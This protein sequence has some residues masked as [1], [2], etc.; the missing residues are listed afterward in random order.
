[1][2]NDVHF[3]IGN[4]DSTG[5]GWV[6]KELDAA[7][8]TVVMTPDFEEGLLWTAEDIV[9]RLMSLTDE[10]GDDLLIVKYSEED[11]FEEVDFLHM[12][13]YVDSENLELTVQSKAR[14]ESDEELPTAGDEEIPRMEDVWR[15]I[16]RRLEGNFHLGEV[17]EYLIALP[18]VSDKEDRRYLASL[19][20][21]HLERY[22]I[23]CE[24][25]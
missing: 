15:V 20:A 2:S 13:D 19:M 17:L 7:E 1:M 4:T 10:F 9:Y 18:S 24:E 22:V 14:D 5:V 12:L 25:N 8:Q 23:S 11:G 21:A 16:E 6:V 3:L